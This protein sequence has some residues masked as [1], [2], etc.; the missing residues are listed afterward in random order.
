MTT[1][2]LFAQ[3]VGSGRFISNTR[4]IAVSR[5]QKFIELSLK[6]QFSK[7][8]SSATESCHSL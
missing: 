6:A 7:K 8:L 4:P 3:S 5:S 2:R 1:F